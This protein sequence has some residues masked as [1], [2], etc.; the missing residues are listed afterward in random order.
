MRK[1]HRQS[2]KCLRYGKI[3]HENNFKYSRAAPALTASVPKFSRSPE[4]T[5]RR[6]RDLSTSTN[7]LLVGRSLFEVWTGPCRAT[8]RAAAPLRLRGQRRSSGAT[9]STPCTEDTT[10]AI[11][12]QRAAMAEKAADR[13][14]SK[15]ALFLKGIAAF[16]AAVYWCV[17]H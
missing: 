14:A 11:D 3:S 10:V 2:L 5:L 4:V 8:T 9:T 1:C 12:E 13:L 6:L 7:L 17:P 15:A 16:R